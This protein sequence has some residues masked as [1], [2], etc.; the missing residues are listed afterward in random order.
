MGLE[1]PKQFLLL[2]GQPVILHSA[3]TLAHVSTEPITV[4]A[5]A[6]FHS[7][8]R[9]ALKGI[10]CRITSGG[11]SRQ[12]STL[13]GLATLAETA[14][15]ED[16]VL[17]HD[18]ARPLITIEEVRRLCD[19]LRSNPGFD[20]ASLVGPVSETIVRIKPGNENELGEPVPRDELRAVKTPQAIRWRA[21]DRLKKFSGDFTD[22]LS[23]AHAAGLPGLLVPCDPANVKLT[24]PSDLPLLESL[25]GPR[26]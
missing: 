26:K 6:N 16:I 10:E 23:W 11:E 19:S 5:P 4:I 18:A 21:I 7:E 8:T 2:A 20:I 24:S 14:S 22:L 9:S 3:A 1:Q 15:S 25:I 12:E 17:I 13:K